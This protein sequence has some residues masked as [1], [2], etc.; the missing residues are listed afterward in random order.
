MPVGPP[1]AHGS[2]WSHW[3]PNRRSHPASEHTTP[4]NAGGS[5]RSNTLCR[6]SVGHPG[7]S[8]RSCSPS[9]RR[10]TPP[11]RTRPPQAGASRTG[12]YPAAADDLNDLT[13]M[14]MPGGRGVEVADEHQI[15]G[16]GLGGGC[17]AEQAL[18]RIRAVHCARVTFRRSPMS[19]VTPDPIGLPIEAIRKALPEFREKRARRSARARASSST[20]CPTSRRSRCRG[21]MSCGSIDARRRRRASSLSAAGSVPPCD[22]Q[23]FGFVLREPRSRSPVPGRVR[24]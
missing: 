5:P 2:L 12:G 16:A 19:S 24:R 23:Q 9:C 11:L 8:A 10:G 4:S 20:Q 7:R 21:W 17:A 14:G 13:R 6:G 22:V 15:G 3:S 1:L 18:E